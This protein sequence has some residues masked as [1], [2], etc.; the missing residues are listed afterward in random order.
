M[1][2]E[3]L[4]K[5]F[6]KKQ[7]K[8]R[9]GNFGK[10]ID[11]VDIQLIIKRLN[12]AFESNWN[13]EIIDNKILDDEVIVT[14]KLTA[15]RICK[16]QFGSN[17]ITKNSK[18]GKPISI[19]DDLKAAS[20]DC[21]KKCASMFGIALHIYGD[22]DIS[23][24][25]V[26]EKK[27]ESL[28][29]KADKKAKEALIEGLRNTYFT[30]LGEAIPTIAKDDLMRTEWQKATIGK[31]SAKEWTK[32]D[33]GKAID[34][35]QN[36]LKRQHEA[37]RK[38][39][40]V[41]LPEIPATDIKYS[42][43]GANLPITDKQIVFVSRLLADNGYKADV[44]NW[45]RGYCSAVIDFLKSSNAK[46]AI[47]EKGKFEE[48]NQANDKLNELVNQL[49]KDEN[50]DQYN[51][52]RYINARYISNVYQEKGMSEKVLNDLTEE[53]QDKH[54]RNA[55]TLNVQICTAFY[56]QHQEEAIKLFDTIL[57]CEQKDN[58]INLIYFQR[59]NIKKLWD[60]SDMATWREDLE[61]V[62]HDLEIEPSF[63]LETIPQ[64]IKK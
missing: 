60:L 45:T 13:F 58:R 18:T 41:E 39:A 11:Y 36:E 50:L 29:E 32:E 22:S 49:A 21:L 2:R 3:L 54:K 4:E 20:S 27:E 44:N 61:A 17:Q 53:L 12:D 47:K 34:F 1:N 56:K 14:G 46:K 33:F 5:Q 59:A 38:E 15:E 8:Q 6:D 26:E 62:M 10:A 55:I 24:P 51:I 35:L 7:I 64:T 52:N 16:M 31:A 30:L 43:N 48:D 19:G 28:Q 42:V 40:F 63:I 25:P 37:E 57:K 23:Q 9:I